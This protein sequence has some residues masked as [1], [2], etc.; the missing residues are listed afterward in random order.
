M[1]YTIITCIII[2]RR[3]EMMEESKIKINLNFNFY[4][5]WEQEE[6]HEALEMYK[7]YAEA[8]A[9]KN[10]CVVEIHINLDAYK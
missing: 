2:S 10:D 4:N 6:L 9:E 3:E 7:E 5:D 8:F 1:T